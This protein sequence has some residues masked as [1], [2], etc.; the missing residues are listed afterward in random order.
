VIFYSTHKDSR[1]VDKSQV[2]TSNNSSPS[3]IFP[4]DCNYSV[5]A[6]VYRI[7][8]RSVLGMAK[9]VTVNVDGG[10]TRRLQHRSPSV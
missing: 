9:L 6:R 3:A 5:F 10:T 4:E 1:I 7:R 8:R 2:A